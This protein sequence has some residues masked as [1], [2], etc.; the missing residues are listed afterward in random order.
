MVRRSTFLSLY[1]VYNSNVS[2]DLTHTFSRFY[3]YSSILPGIRS[4]AAACS[5][6]SVRP[7]VCLS[8]HG[9][10]WK[11]KRFLYHWL[12]GFI[13]FSKWN[14]NTKKYIYVCMYVC[15]NTYTNFENIKPFNRRTIQQLFTCQMPRFI[16]IDWL[17][18][19]LTGWEEDGR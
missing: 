2:Q 11:T 18:G 16:W 12:S 15:T 7:S 5:H 10:I 4:L 9:L 3:R 17:A 13:K 1:I 8:V 19:W 6:L 14:W